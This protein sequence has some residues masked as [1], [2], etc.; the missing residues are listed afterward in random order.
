M[1]APIVQFRGLPADP[2]EEVA[3]DQGAVGRVRD[4]G[5]ELEPEEG[6]RPVLDRGDRAGRGHGQRDEVRAGVLDLVAVAHPDDRL[7]GDAVEERLVGVEDPALGPA[8]L[9]RRRRL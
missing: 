4:L 2:V 1:N 5:M 9:P 6:E 8:E 3:Q 7:A